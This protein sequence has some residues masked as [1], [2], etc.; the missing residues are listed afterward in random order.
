MD[1]ANF[2]YTWYSVDKQHS[3][4]NRPGAMVDYMSAAEEVLKEA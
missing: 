2:L 1:Y 4:P 3:S